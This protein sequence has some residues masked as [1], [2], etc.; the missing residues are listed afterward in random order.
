MGR[1]FYEEISTP[2]SFI[3]SL[4]HRDMAS[5]PTELC[6]LWALIKREE[7]CRTDTVLLKYSV[8]LSTTQSLGLDKNP[9]NSKGLRWAPGFVSRCGLSPSQDTNQKG[10]LFT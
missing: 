2:A 8:R 4:H 9:L 7:Q 3:T 1:I 5:T 10:K 6:G